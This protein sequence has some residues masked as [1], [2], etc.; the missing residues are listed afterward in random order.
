M[1][2]TGLLI[3]GVFW[4]LPVILLAQEPAESPRQRALRELEGILAETDNLADKLAYV[5]VRARAANLLW[6]HDP[7]RARTIFRELWKLVDEQTEALFD[8][9]AA[10][11]DLLKNLF[12]R[13]RNTARALLEKALGGHKSEE[14]PYRAQIAGTDHNVRRLVRLSSELVEQ[15]PAMAAALLERSLSVSVS[16]AALLTLFR[17]REQDP[18][19]ADYIVARTLEVLRMRP[20]VIAL[21]GVYVLADYVFPSMPSFGNPGTRPPDISLRVQYVSTAYEILQRSLAESESTLQREERYTEKDLHFRR[22]YQ[23][24]VAALLSALAPRYLPER[25]QELKTRAATL[26]ADLPP[27]TARLLRFTLARIS[28]SVRESEDLEMVISVAL[29]RGDVDKARRALEKLEDENTKKA[30]AQSIANVEFRAHLAKSNLAEAL[31][32]ARRV[33]DPNLRGSLYAQVARA[34]HRKGEVNLSRMILIEARAALSTSEP[35]GVRVRTLL[36]LASEASA[37]SASEAVQLLWDAVSA[38]NALKAMSGADATRDSLA[39]INDPR[40]FSEATE[41][42]RAFSSV[43]RV[44]LEG[45]LWTAHQIRDEVVRLVA[46]LAACQEWLAEAGEP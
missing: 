1:R 29:A 35:N 18:S 9:E 16:P 27:E 6:L 30:F 5:K 7:D 26:A 31:M 33:E 22:V 11:T 20:T 4:S 40:S 38:L 12:P 42:W 34:A 32:A 46:R 37:I 3:L 15:D 44:D 41:L 28:G 39:K 8:R 2:V 24:Q 10:R 14:A 21:P 19:L 23:G 17:L 36:S 25:A 43:G 45:A 13:D